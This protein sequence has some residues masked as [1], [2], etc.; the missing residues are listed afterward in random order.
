[1]LMLKSGLRSLAG[2]KGQ[3]SQGQ[4]SLG[5]KPANRWGDRSPLGSVLPLRLAVF[6]PQLNQPESS[7]SQVTAFFSNGNNTYSMPKI[8]S[9]PKNEKNHTKNLKNHLSSHHLQISLVGFWYISC[10]LPTPPPSL[11]LSL[12]LSCSLSLSRIYTQCVQTHIY[13]SHYY[14]CF[15]IACF[16]VL[17]HFKH[18]AMIIDIFKPQFKN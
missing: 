4:H 1:M 16:Y 6:E 3:G 11:A 15:L 7:F 12:A 13:V 8:C 9:V 5:T 17:T 2:Q 10:F 14:T 18:F